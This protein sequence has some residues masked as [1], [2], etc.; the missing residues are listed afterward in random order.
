M[1]IAANEIPMQTPS[2][3]YSQAVQRRLRFFAHKR[4]SGV[5]EA[6]KPVPFD[7]SSRIVFFSDC[8]RG[9][10]G[11]TDGF[12]QNKE[13]F[14][15]A[16]N[17]YY[18]EAYTYI[19]VGD[20]DELWVNR[21]FSDVRHAYRHIYDLLH[22][23]DRRNRLHLVVGN[24]D[25]Q[26]LR[27]DRVEKDG[28]VAHEGLLLQHARNGQ[29]IFV[30]H[31]HQADFKSDRLRVASQF[32]VRYVWKRMQLL[33][34]ARAKIPTGDFEKRCPIEQRIVEWVQARRQIVV[35]GHTHRPRFAARGAPPY[36]NAGSCLHPGALTGLE[37]EGGKIAMVR[38]STRPETR[39]G[40]APHVQRELVAPPRELGVIA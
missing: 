12:A 18:H 39:S 15:H 13:L 32:A 16:L 5:L 34:L 23:F 33:G 11:V 2:P 17:Y 7:D 8:H 24:H 35:C 21:R 14:F 37:I 26:G 3:G 29:R 27:R 28:I 1:N 31:G 4:L 9:D 25:I 6:A 22:R 20:G 38:W 36:F 40:D 30:V 19:E 10:N